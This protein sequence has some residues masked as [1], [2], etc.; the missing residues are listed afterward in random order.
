MASL[1]MFSKSVR[2]WCCLRFVVGGV[3][4]SRLEVLSG[5]CVGGAFGKRGELGEACSRRSK[6][7][8]LGDRNEE[9]GLCD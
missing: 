8:V 4:E 1:V 6:L 3:K 5:L 2:L 7:C 9:K